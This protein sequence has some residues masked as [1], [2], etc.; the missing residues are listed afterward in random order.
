MRD[1]KIRKI[2]AVVAVLAF[3]ALAGACDDG[4]YDFDG[5]PSP[6]V[7]PYVRITADP[8]TV[9]KGGD[10]TLK[11]TAANA[12]T[13]QIASADGSEFTFRSEPIDVS[14]ETESSG[15]TIVTGMTATTTFIITAKLTME[16]VGGDF[17]VNPAPYIPSESMRKSG[18]IQFPIA[19]PVLSESLI[20]DSVTVE[21]IDSTLSASLIA[22]PD[23]ISQGDSSTLKCEYSPEDATVTVTDD[24]GQVIVMDEDCE[25][26]VTPDETT[27]YEVTVTDNNTGA[28]ETD[29]A[30]VHVAPLYADAADITAKDQDVQATLDS[31]DEQFSV[32]YIIDPTSIPVTVEVDKAGVTCTPELPIDPTTY[33][34]LPGESMCT[35]TETTTFSL[36]SHIGGVTKVEDFVT[37]MGPMGTGDVDI[38]VSHAWAFE[39]EDVIIEVAAKDE[40]AVPMIDKIRIKGMVDIDIN[41]GEIST[42]H[43][44]KNVI[45]PMVDVMV[46]VYSPQDAPDSPSIIKRAVAALPLMPI[47]DI[48]E[49]ITKVLID[50]YDISRAYFGVLTN[51]KEQYQENFSQTVVKMYR[52]EELS[53]NVT[54]NGDLDIDLGYLMTTS[55]DAFVQTMMNNSAQFM[56]SFRDYPINAIALTD[57][58]IYA[59][60]YGAIVRSSDNGASWELLGGQILPFWSSKKDENGAHTSC[61]GETARGSKAPHDDDLIALINVCDIVLH[62]GGL[63]AGTDFGIFVAHDIETAMTD[64]DDFTNVIWNNSVAKA[65]P[66]F[67]NIVNDVAKVT[68]DGGTK[69]FAAVAAGNWPNGMSNG[70][71]R[72]VFVSTAGDGAGIGEVWTAFG[73]IDADVY[74]VEID[75]DNNEAKKIYAATENGVYVSDLGQAGSWTLT[76]LTEAAYSLADDPYS[77]GMIIAGLADGVKVTRNGGD[78]WGELLAGGLAGSGKIS[79]VALAAS[80]AT[81]S[82]EGT[83]F[84]ETGDKLFYRAIFGSGNGG[85]LIGKTLFD[86]V[87]L[88]A[89]EDQPE[90]QPEDNPPEENPDDPD[91]PLEMIH[92]IRA[93]AIPMQINN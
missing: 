83:V 10:T 15:E 40:A 92:E 9:T 22:D 68:K 93:V 65:Q 79:S 45:V 47:G 54:T 69:L 76:A 57:S 48:D 18:Q 20:T 82:A 51:V 11:W 90:D 26:L 85:Y 2:L 3:A 37:V 70:T 12:D 91:N 84:G 61:K 29:T 33:D 66:M 86:A 32:K 63:I 38:R 28:V 13:V 31:M 80:P 46:E 25:A 74:A 19:E 41:K 49:P 59:G 89:A 53:P 55:S 88:P 7:S 34:Q 36:V 17:S 23:H 87:A 73:T 78:N 1:G 58:M 14:G 60:T 21:V 81:N 35:I 24:D 42:V 67:G 72:G 16:V 4:R 50:P 56:N 8:M 30:I 39:G 75:M 71:A 6:D 43:I 27:V 5:S 62:D 77:T 44:A 52:S 64:P